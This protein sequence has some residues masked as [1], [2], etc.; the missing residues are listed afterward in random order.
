M[1]A[2]TWKELKAAR[3][4][5]YTSQDMAG[6]TTKFN[7]W[8][9]IPRFVLL[10]LDQEDQEDREEDL[11]AAVNNCSID[12]LKSS[13]VDLNNASDPEYNHMLLHMTVREDHLKGPVVFAS[14][15]G[16]QPTPTMQQ[17]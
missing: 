3:K 2:W 8:G 10:K 14:D 4:L 16:D 9:G 1:P 5:I 13:M 11:Q 17:A 7:K 12:D 15:G 6:M